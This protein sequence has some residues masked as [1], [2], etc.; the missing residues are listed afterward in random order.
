MRAL[1]RHTGLQ[2]GA[3]V[4]RKMAASTCQHAG[5]D[6]GKPHERDPSRRCYQPHL[7]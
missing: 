4:R 7:E 6:A 2:V 3:A 5:R 1:R